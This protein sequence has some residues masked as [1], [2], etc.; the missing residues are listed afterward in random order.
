M[1][2]RRLTP[3]AES[4][5]D[6]ASHKPRFV[7]G[8]LCLQNFVSHQARGHRDGDGYVNDARLI[9]GVV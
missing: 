8:V 4:S 9:R 7:R 1:C 2:R 3:R 5:S 6:F